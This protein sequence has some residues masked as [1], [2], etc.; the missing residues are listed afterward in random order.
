MSTVNSKFDAKLVLN[1]IIGEELAESVKFYKTKE[2]NVFVKFKANEDEVDSGKL[3]KF[4]KWLKIWGNNDSKFNK[5]YE[6]TIVNKV[7][8][9]NRNKLKITSFLPK[10]PPLSHPEKARC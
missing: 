2:N 9:K 5:D 3:E 7:D 6:W 4:K 8:T 1:E 10:S